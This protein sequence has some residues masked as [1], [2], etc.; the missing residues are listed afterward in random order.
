[1][2]DLIVVG[3]GIAGLAF[4]L[5][6]IEQGQ[7][8]LVIE[9]NKA[10]LGASIRN[11]GMVLPLGMPTGNALNRAIKSR[12]KWLD[13]SKK[14]NFWA[15]PC[16][17]MM[18]AHHDDEMTAME[19]FHNHHSLTPY[20]TRLLD[21]DQAEVICPGVNPKGLI[22]GLLSQTEVQINPQ[23]AI[24]QLTHYLDKQDDADL[25]FSTRV[26]QIH[27][28]DSGVDVHTNQGLFH[29]KKIVCCPGH[30]FSDLFSTPEQSKPITCK[31]Q[32]MR[33]IKQKQN[34]AFG[35]MFSTGLSMLHYPAFDKVKSLEAVKERVSYD[36]PELI[37][38]GI[39]ILAAQNQLGEITLG[40]SHHYGDD[41]DPFIDQEVN[42]L[43]TQYA[44]KVMQLPSWEIKEQW[45]GV[46]SKAQ[47]DHV[48]WT[49]PQDHVFLVTG[50]G[51]TGMSTSFAIAEEWFL[52]NA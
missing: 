19:E 49:Q 2:Y 9:K 20:R 10:A 29:G 21:P 50:L 39:H 15:N 40:D 30:E 13:Y 32:M 26:I 28:K 4:A 25:I 43:I 31:L 34:W 3:A 1:M 36:Y 52:E 16:G 11:F 27:T 33:T 41:P 38:H 37:E 42:Y 24:K 45:M 18:A 46:Y 5:T 7:S 35:S 44:K 14:A 12:E 17:M 23:Q 22:G 48:Y 47:D 6:A 51:G 8:V